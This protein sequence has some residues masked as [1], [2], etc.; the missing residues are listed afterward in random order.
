MKL[1]GTIDLNDYNGLT[2][3]SERYACRAIIKKDNKLIMVHS[4]KGEYKFPGGGIE[5]NESKID[6][7]IREVKEETGLIVIEESIKPFGKIIEKRK[8]S[9]NEN[10]IFIHTSYYFTCEVLDIRFNQKLDEYEIEEDFTLSYVTP[11]EALELN[12]TSNIKHT[13]RENMILELLK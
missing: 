6:A 5:D 10:T 12:L 13:L 1:L 11:K 4:N 2:K 7:L 3:V 9:I 8:S